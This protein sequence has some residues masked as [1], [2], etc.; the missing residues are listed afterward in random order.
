MKVG[1]MTSC[2]GH[3]KQNCRFLEREKS[4]GSE[5][6]GKVVY[7]K[8]QSSHLPRETGGIWPFLQKYTEI[9]PGE[10]AAQENSDRDPYKTANRAMLLRTVSYILTGK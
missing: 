8:T 7:L 5:V 1:S 3:K 4:D 2:T 9:I 10:G 6:I